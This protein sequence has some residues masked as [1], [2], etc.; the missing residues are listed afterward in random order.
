MKRIHYKS[1]HI[2]DSHG[3]WTVIEKIPSCT[4]ADNRDRFIKVACACGTVRTV[5]IISQNGD[6]EAHH[7]GEK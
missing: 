3:H 2:G 1:W 4:K 7:L 5:T 6:G